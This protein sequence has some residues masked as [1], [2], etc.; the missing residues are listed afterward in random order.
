LRKHRKVTKFLTLESKRRKTQWKQTKIKAL[1][2][3]PNSTFFELDSDYLADSG[4]PSDKLILYCR[5]TFHDQFTFLRERVINNSRFGW[6]LG[7]P[8]TGKSTTALA[9]ASTLIGDELVVTWIHLSRTYSPVCVRFEGD[10]KKTRKF[11]DTEEL[12]DILSEVSSKKKYYI[13]I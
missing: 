1:T 10:S 6:I 5:S 13:I 3:D 2:Y 7:P 4:L 11:K 8:G 9:F 12:E